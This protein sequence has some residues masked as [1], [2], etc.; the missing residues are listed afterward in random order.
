MVMTVPKFFPMPLTD[1]N[2][3]PTMCGLFGDMENK[4]DMLSI[5][6]AEHVSACFPS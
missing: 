1:I 4:L 2:M 5:Y 6:L 3:L